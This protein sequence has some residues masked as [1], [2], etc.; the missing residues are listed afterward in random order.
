MLGNIFFTASLLWHYI[1]N[2]IKIKVLFSAQPEGQFPATYPISEIT[3]Q[4]GTQPLDPNHSHF[5]LVDDGSRDKFGGEI[6]WRA[7]FEKFL[8]EHVLSG[9]ETKAGKDTGS[10]C[11]YTLASLWLLT[12]I[13]LFV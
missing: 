7:E 8:M 12:L 11:Q 5:I 6:K 2:I 4:K 1:A 10:L 9:M 13:T 3:G